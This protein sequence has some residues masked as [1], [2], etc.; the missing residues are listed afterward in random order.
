MIRRDQMANKDLSRTADTHGA[1][2]MV[3]VDQYVLNKMLRVIQNPYQV[4]EEDRAKVLKY[5]SDTLADPDADRKSKQAA[6][7]ILMM[8]DEINI[9]RFEVVDKVNRLE[10]GQA[11]ENVQVVLGIPKTI[12]QRTPQK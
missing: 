11:T 6:A 7:K 10:S 3:G 9:R 8:A 2:E 1:A 12:S 5:A 4:S